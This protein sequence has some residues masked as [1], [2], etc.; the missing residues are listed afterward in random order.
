M[1][2]TPDRALAEVGDL[3]KVKQSADEYTLAVLSLTP[4]LLLET[5]TLNCGTYGMP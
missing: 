1:R 2:Y 3:E 5:S 4:F